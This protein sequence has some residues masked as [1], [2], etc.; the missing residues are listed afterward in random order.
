MVKMEA[1][2]LFF[3]TRRTSKIKSTHIMIIVAENRLSF[4]LFK[5]CVSPFKQCLTPFKIVWGQLIGSF[6]IHQNILLLLMPVLGK[7]SHCNLEFF[8]KTIN[9]YHHFSVPT[10]FSWQRYC[11]ISV[12]SAALGSLRQEWPPLFQPAITIALKPS[13]T[14]TLWLTPKFS[15]FHHLLSPLTNEHMITL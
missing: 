5:T 2:T 12:S 14:D 1:L 9:P 8:R 4:F 3:T 10:I 13:H 15:F 11:F 6:V 7:K